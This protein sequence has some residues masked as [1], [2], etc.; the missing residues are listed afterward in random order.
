MPTATLS[1]IGNTSGIFGL[2]IFD[3]NTQYSTYED[4]KMG[5]K[6]IATEMTYDTLLKNMYA[7]GKEVYSINETK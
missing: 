5:M 3:L 6:I 1:L 2:H 7:V 4:P